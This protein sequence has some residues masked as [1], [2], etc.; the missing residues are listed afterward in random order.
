MLGNVMILCIGEEFKFLMVSWYK[1]CIPISEGVWGSK[2][3][4]CS[5]ELFWGI[6]YGA[7]LMWRFVVDF[8]YSNL[9]GVVF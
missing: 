4:F 3:Y 5:T 8:K 9:W 7:T 6:G 2:I 1:V